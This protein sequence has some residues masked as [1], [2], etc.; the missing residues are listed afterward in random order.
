MA[1][2]RGSLIVADHP[3]KAEAQEILEQLLRVAGQPSRSVTL[4]IVRGGEGMAVA[5]CALR[6]INVAESWLNGIQEGKVASRIRKMELANIL[7]HELAHILK[8][9]CSDHPDAEL[10]ADRLAIQWSKQ[11]GYGCTWLVN[12]RKSLA[13]KKGGDTGRFSTTWGR[14]PDLGRRAYEQD[15]RLCPSR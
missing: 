4:F 9:G 7:G 3:L 11:A 6:E 10:E 8:A 1:E 2:R 12:F 14:Y 13:E 15:Q 5:N